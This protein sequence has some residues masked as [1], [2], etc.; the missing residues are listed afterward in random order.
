[1]PSAAAGVMIGVSTLR[2]SWWSSQSRMARTIVARTRI[3]AHW[4]DERSHKW[5]FSIRELDAVLFRL[6]R[7]RVGDAKRLEAAHVDLEAAWNPWRARVRLDYA[8]YD[9][10]ALLR[11]RLGNLEILFRNI[12]AEDYRLTD[13]SAI[14]HLQEN[15]FA[16][17]GFSVTPALDGHFLIDVLV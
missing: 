9:H 2:K 1:V 11:H 5:R 12:A 15:Q 17:A 8:A 13:A 10:A 3:A 4:R 7:V 16:F 6:D 14:A